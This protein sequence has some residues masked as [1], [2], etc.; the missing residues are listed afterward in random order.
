MYSSNS[1]PYFSCA[2]RNLH[3]PP[4]EASSWFDRADGGTRPVRIKNFSKGGSSALTA[5]I[6]LAER[7]GE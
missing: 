6:M 7:R 3:P 1:R 4:V 2:Q 5:N